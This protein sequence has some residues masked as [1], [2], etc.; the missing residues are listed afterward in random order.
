ML[1]QAHHTGGTQVYLGQ[2]ALL[3]GAYTMH[4][5]EGIQ[6]YDGGV[7]GREGADALDDGVGGLV[8]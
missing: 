5:V 1:V 6:T 7:G 8:G 2:V 4:P 3:V